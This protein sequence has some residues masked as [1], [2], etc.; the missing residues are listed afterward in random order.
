[1]ETLMSGLTFIC[2]SGRR[3]IDG[4]EKKRLRNSINSSKCACRIDMLR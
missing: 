2:V 3:I 1:M 4:E